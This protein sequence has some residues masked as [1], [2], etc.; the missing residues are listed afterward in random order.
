MADHAYDLVLRG[1]TVFDGS[2]AP[3][4]VADVAVRSGLIAAV[5]QTLPRG[6]K[7]L[8]RP[9]GSSRRALSTST[10]TMTA[11]PPGTTA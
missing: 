9:A 6:G 7:R 11:R 8:T 10:P 4:F 3:G 2:G 5:G 1:G